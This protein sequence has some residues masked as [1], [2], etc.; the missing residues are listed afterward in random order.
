MMFR[1][2]QVVEYLVRQGIHR[3][4][5]SGRYSSR[6]EWSMAANKRRDA[7]R[8][9]TFLREAQAALGQLQVALCAGP[10]GLLF[11]LPNLRESMNGGFCV[12]MHVQSNSHSKVV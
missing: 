9:L 4:G 8:G 11:H 3:S 1:R 2:S 7:G 6:Q 10:Q 5:D 12:A